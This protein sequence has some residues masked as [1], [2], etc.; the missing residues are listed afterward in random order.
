MALSREALRE[1]ANQLRW[2]LITLETEAENLREDLYEEYYTPEVREMSRKA[3][4]ACDVEAAR[5]KGLIALLE[6]ELNEAEN[7]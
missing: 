6:D 5:V 1:I 3:A 7:T 2:R 4:A